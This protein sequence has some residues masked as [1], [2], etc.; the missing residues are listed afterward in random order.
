MRWFDRC[1]YFLDAFSMGLLVPVMTL[2]FLSHG[3][4]VATLSLFV[5]VA[6][7]TIVAAELPSGIIV[8]MIGRKKIFILAHVFRIVSYLFLYFW[9]EPVTLFFSMICRGIAMAFSSGSYEALLVEQYVK[10]HGEG[11]LSRIN[12]ILM[13]MDG[14]GCGLAAI[15]GG[16]LG[17]IGKDYRLLLVV[18]LLLDSIILFLSIFCIEE[19]WFRKNQHRPFEEWKNH[20]SLMCQG[21]GRSRTVGS[22]LFLSAMMG[23]LVS[24]V[25]SY[26]QQ[27]MVQMLP[28]QRRW[29]LGL[30]SCLAYL[31][32][33]WGSKIGEKVID[34]CN[35][36]KKWIE[37]KKLC[38]I[39]RILLAISIMVLGV[40]RNAMLFV[41]LYSIV[42]ILVG[43][44]DLCERTILHR[45]I[46]NK[47]RASMLSVYSLF[48]RG[49]A[50][51][52]A[53]LT[54]GIVSHYD[55]SYVWIL[56]PVIALGGM[57]IMIVVKKLCR[58]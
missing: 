6:A 48:I 49:G 53:L 46:E 1:I 41:V 23:L 17:M 31:C 42:Y 24:V 25:E 51:V 29:L 2:V 50:V 39:Y 15:L 52:S 13:Q 3:A 34:L 35:N 38:W 22:L 27:T 28:E 37:E 18:I 5:A 57:A 7:V 36:D 44:G 10:I 33:M 43:A 9:K 8:D 20:I 56:T 47:Y 55:I 45:E 21:V 30:I 40:A 16:F 32:S 26:W 58:R 54:S 11:Q 19:E 12:R 4:T 14:A